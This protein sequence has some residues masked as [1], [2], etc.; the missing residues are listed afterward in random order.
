MQEHFFLDNDDIKISSTRLVLE[1][2]TIAMSSV[3]SVELDRE[4][5]KKPWIGMI[6]ALI[7]LVSAFTYNDSSIG[8]LVSFFGLLL[9]VIM[10]FRKRK[11]AVIIE[12][13]SG[14]KEYLTNEEIEDLTS[15]FK[16]VNDVI[17]FRG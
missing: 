17:I 5:L 14:E 16:A 11:E 1:N 4:E 8:W 2:K 3:C 12:L 13:T 6:I 7:G 15:V 9:V 10:L